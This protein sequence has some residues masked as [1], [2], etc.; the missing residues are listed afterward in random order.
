MASKKK[1]IRKNVAVPERTRVSVVLCM[2][3]ILEYIKTT[4]WLV[5]LV[6]GKKACEEMHHRH[7][8]SRKTFSLVAY[9]LIVSNQISTFF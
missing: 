2:V 6:Q 5:I 1:C 8:G 4:T 7:K 3:G 9:L